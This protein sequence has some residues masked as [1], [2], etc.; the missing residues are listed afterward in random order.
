MTEMFIFVNKTKSNSKVVGHLISVNRGLPHL[1]YH[2][3]WVELWGM[4][5]LLWSL[6][7]GGPFCD[8]PVC[9][10]AKLG[11][12]SLTMLST[13][14]SLQGWLGSV[15]GPST[16]DIIIQNQNHSKL[17]K[18][19]VWVLSSID[20][21]YYMRYMY[22][23][24]KKFLSTVFSKFLKSSLQLNF[25][26]GKGWHCGGPKHMLN[27]PISWYSAADTGLLKVI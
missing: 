17:S 5:M 27:L 19:G 8:P 21:R 9:V 3:Y 22:A 16:E 23:E 4:G 10:C 26:R 20:F 15:E 11:D 6:V 14:P 18:S 12:C 7:L 24:I 25:F 2:L 13:L 1:K